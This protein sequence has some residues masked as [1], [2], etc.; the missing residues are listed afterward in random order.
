MLSL[1][2]EASWVRCLSL[3]RYTPAAISSAR[4]T[5]VPA[6]RLSAQSVFCLRSA[7]PKNSATSGPKSSEF[8]AR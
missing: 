6:P 3:T 7:A 5:A 4:T 8:S 1:A 2:A